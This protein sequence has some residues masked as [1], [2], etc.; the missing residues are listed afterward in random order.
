[1]EFVHYYDL[2]GNTHIVNVG[3]EEDVLNEVEAYG[4]ID[5]REL[6]EGMIER[7]VEEAVN[8]SLE[9][10]R[11]RKYINTLESETNSL[12]SKLE[13]FYDRYDRFFDDVD[14]ILEEKS[15][16]ERLEKKE[17]A[18]IPFDEHFQKLMDN[19]EEVMIYVGELVEWIDDLE[20]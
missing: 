1:M 18:F 12:E 8:S 15:K 19:W 11:M 14:E 16:K 17:K 4:G 9:L 3:N 13:L 2:D 20:S 7:K 5:L 6:V 10:R